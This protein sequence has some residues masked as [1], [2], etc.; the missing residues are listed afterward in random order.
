MQTNY[1]MQMNEAAVGLS[2]E[3]ITERQRLSGTD[4]RSLQWAQEESPVQRLFYMRSSVCRQQ[5]RM[6]SN[7]AKL[8]N[9]VIDLSYWIHF[10]LFSRLLQRAALKNILYNPHGK[11]IVKTY[12]SYS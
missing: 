7:T 5:D 11:E 8:E 10:K 1:H 4:T 2:L 3:Y 9:K 6:E 12:M